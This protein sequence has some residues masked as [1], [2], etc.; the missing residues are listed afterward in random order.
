MLVHVLATEQSQGTVE[1]DRHVAWRRG[2]LSRDGCC[3]GGG[4]EG[5]WWTGEG[6]LVRVCVQ[7]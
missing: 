6:R 7:F 2:G 4:G 1:G 3:E 5:E